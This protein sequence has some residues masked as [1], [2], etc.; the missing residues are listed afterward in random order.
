MIYSIEKFLSDNEY[1]E[2]I[3]EYKACVNII[4]HI[5]MYIDKKPLIFG[6]P[7]SIEGLGLVYG[8]KNYRGLFSDTDEVS[9]LFK[10]QSNEKCTSYLPMNR[11][12]LDEVY[13]YVKEHVNKQTLTQNIL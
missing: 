9:Y 8:I 3:D 4:Q 2:I 12:I 5:E 7:I 10:N 1:L 13:H 11:D 6:K